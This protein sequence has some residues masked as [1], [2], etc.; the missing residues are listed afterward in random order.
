MSTDL[1]LSTRQDAGRMSLCERVGD[2]LQFVEKIGTVFFL[3]KAGGVKTQSE[4]QLMALTCLME[5]K[6]PFE[7]NREF[8]L[9]DGKLTMKADAMLAKFRQS[10]GK[11]VWLNLGEDGVEAVL[12]LQYR[13]EKEYTISFSIQKAKDAGYVKAGSQWLKRPDQMLRAR[14]ITDG[15]RL[16][17]PEIIAGYYTPEEMEDVE[18]SKQTEPAA[19][20]PKVAKTA[21][22]ATATQQ[23]QT[24]QQPQTQPQQPQ[25]QGEIVDA[26]YVV[27]PDTTTTTAAAAA[28]TPVATTATATTEEPSFSLD[29]Q[30]HEMTV[31]L[32]E[33]QALVEK[34]GSTLPEFEAS[35]RTKLPDF[36]TVDAMPLDRLKKLTEKVR[37]KANAAEQELA[38]AGLAGSAGK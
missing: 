20:K 18:F 38:T 26:E 1:A 36:T 5:G 7:I 12:W 37:Q 13:G 10:G 6:S 21:V 24:A 29:P 28:T 34:T 25:P 30:N 3:S 14:C 11:N 19:T 16:A 27:T 2:P 9:M 22:S 35:L 32:I 4:G 33:I 8:H 17:A 23:T 31:T 15:V